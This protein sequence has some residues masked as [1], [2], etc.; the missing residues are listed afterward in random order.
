M[1]LSYPD[2]RWGQ[3]KAQMIEIAVTHHTQLVKVRDTSSLSVVSIIV[4][5]SDC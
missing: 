3:Y 4:E 5:R 1:G 2:V